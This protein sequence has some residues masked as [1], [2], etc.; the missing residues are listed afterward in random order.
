MK[1]P[2]KLQIFSSKEIQKL[3][4]SKRED[5]RGNNIINGDRFWCA[6]ISSSI[7]VLIILIWF[8]T[9]PIIILNLD[10][11]KFLWVFSFSF[12][13]FSLIAFE[14]RYN[15]VSPLP[16]YIVKYPLFIFAIS[17]LVFAIVYILIR[18]SEEML[19]YPLSLSLSLFLSY[20]VDSLLKILGR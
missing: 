6:I 4:S 16:E 12:L 8:F 11:S 14:Q 17:C 9:K 7:F 18:A 5:L 3:D 1:N 2:I 20:N 15:S 13:G 19:F 10:I